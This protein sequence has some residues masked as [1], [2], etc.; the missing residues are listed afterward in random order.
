MI[1]VLAKINRVRSVLP[2]STKTTWLINQAANSTR[3]ISFFSDE[4]HLEDCATVLSRV[5]FLLFLFYLFEEYF[6]PL[7]VV[8]LL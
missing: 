8:A 7:Q 1:S 3:R 4:I 6:N 5:K 2:T